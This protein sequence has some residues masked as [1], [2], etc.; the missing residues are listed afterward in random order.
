MNRRKSWSKCESKESL[1][2]ATYIIST[3]LSYCSL[4]YSRLPFELFKS[5]IESASF[6]GSDRSIFAFTKVRSLSTLGSLISLLSFELTSCL[7]LSSLLIVS[8]PPSEHHLPATAVPLAQLRH[9]LISH[10]G[11]RCS[12]VRS[13]EGREQRVCDSEGREEGER[14]VEG[15][16]RETEGVWKTRRERFAQ[17]G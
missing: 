17:L 6:P 1:L 12:L 11:K 10:R 15:W 4:S 5:S 3:D 8:V 13:E 7:F 16:L 14:V 2:A 9:P